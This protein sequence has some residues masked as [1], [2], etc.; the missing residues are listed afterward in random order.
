MKAKKESFHVAMLGRTDKMLPE[1]QINFFPSVNG[2]KEG[3][4]ESAETCSADEASHFGK[5]SGLTG[6]KFRAHERLW[7]TGY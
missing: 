3:T 7:R 5:A 1:L 2:S 4:K 6:S